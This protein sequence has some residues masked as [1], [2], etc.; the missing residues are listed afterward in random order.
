MSASLVGARGT[1]S[2]IL[3]QASTVLIA[4]IGSDLALLHLVEEATQAAG[5]RTNIDTGRRA[6]PVGKNS[7]HVRD[8]GD[9]DR[10][11]EVYVHQNVAGLGS[12]WNPVPDEL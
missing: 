3:V 5:W 12:V 6:F 1:F 9:D 10:G 4:K 2:E 8:L 11:G 7:R